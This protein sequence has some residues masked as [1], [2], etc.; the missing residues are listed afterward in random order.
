MTMTKWIFIYSEWLLLRKL[1]AWTHSFSRPILMKIRKQGILIWPSPDSIRNLPIGHC[2][3]KNNAIYARFCSSFREFLIFFSLTL[4]RSHFVSLCLCL[5]LVHRM[6]RSKCLS[7]A[8]EAQTK[9]F[10]V[11]S[12]TRS[13]P[14][15]YLITREIDQ[16]ECDCDLLLDEC[17]GLRTTWHAECVSW[18]RSPSNLWNESMRCQ[19]NFLTSSFFRCLSNALGMHQSRWR[20]SVFFRGQRWRSLSPVRQYALHYNS[21]LSMRCAVQLD[22]ASRQKKTRWFHWFCFGVFF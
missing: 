12:R 3:R 18:V 8:D 13:Q 17:I 2:G 6:S 11:T 15:K 4:Y 10:V 14:N 21:S 7:L 5:S 19:H 22:A 16:I 9:T 1:I 20:F